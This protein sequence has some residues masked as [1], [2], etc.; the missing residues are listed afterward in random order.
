MQPMAPTRVS[1]LMKRLAIM[2]ALAVAAGAV[3]FLQRPRTTTAA[4]APAPPATPTP[5]PATAT[6]RA[7]PAPRP[8]RPIDHVTKLDS[9]EQRRALAD[10]IAA[11][12]SAGA[13]R[14]APMPRLP[15]GSDDDSAPPISKTE[16]RTAMREIVPHLAACYEA[17]LPTL[18]NPQLSVVTE[19]TLTGDP[20]IGTL[21]D[22]HQIS[23]KDGK[24]LPA[25]FDDCL[26]T[27]LQLL[28][29]PP[30][31]EGDEIKVRYP[32]EFRPN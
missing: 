4:E 21:I 5:A 1:P 31:A 3:W 11:S 20:D 6:G 26:R 9:L 2:L 29:L 16:I 30:L 28:A 32:F 13:T 19:L 8:A 25:T 14:V 17:A 10:R 15:T 22:A 18:A 27:N 24:P 12:R 7:V 23:D